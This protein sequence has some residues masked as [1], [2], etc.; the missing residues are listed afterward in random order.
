[1]PIYEVCEE[2]EQEGDDLF[3]PSDYETEASSEEDAVRLYVIDTFTNH[4]TLEVRELSEDKTIKP[5]KY[6]VCLSVI[7]VRLR[8]L[9]LP[10]TQYDSFVFCN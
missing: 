3:S 7:K 4:D 8:L 2:F 1:M 5:S 6:T 9:S 10:P